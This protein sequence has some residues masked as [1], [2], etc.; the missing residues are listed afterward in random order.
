M[1]QLVWDGQREKGGGNEQGN[2]IA[3][4]FKTLGPLGPL[5][6]YYKIK[7]RMTIKYTSLSKTTS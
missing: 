2:Y 6:K 7:I 5:E 1:N 3:S 4:S